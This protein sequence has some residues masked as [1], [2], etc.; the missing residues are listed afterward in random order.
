MSRLIYFDDDERELIRD[1]YLLIYCL[2]L[3]SEVS[4]PLSGC[5]WPGV[6]KFAYF[7]EGG[8][9]SVDIA[10]TYPHDSA[11]QVGVS[12]YDVYLEN[13]LGNTIHSC[14]NRMIWII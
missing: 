10:W 13:T 1:I 11:T 2:G 8:Q 14:L 12:S 5:S 7:T 6:P 4:V 3:I 9:T